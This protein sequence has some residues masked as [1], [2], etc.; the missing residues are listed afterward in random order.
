MT[1]NLKDPVTT[2]DGTPV[3][4]IC[5][6]R[7]ENYPVMGYI[8]D[9]TTLSFWDAEGGHNSSNP[10]LDLKNLPI[11]GEVWVVVLADGTALYVTEDGARSTGIRISA[12]PALPQ[13]KAV[14]RL[15]YSVEAGHNDLEP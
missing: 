10:H 13:I 3:T 1:L 6:G 7:D 14:I 2:Q 12:T 15:P 8:G 5:S 9:A 4:L 11:S